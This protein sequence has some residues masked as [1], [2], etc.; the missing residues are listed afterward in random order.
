MKVWGGGGR[1]INQN[2]LRLLPPPVG[3]KAGRTHK[4]ATEALPVREVS[5]SCAGGPG[6]LS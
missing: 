2:H 1:K 3:L 4:M 6:K 5:A